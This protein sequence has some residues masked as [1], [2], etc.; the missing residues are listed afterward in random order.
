MRAHA[1]A[2]GVRAVGMHA[3]VRSRGALEAQPDTRLEPGKRLEAM[4]AG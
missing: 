1:I 4:G 2:S 3:V